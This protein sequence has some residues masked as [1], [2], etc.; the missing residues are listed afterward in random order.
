M[1]ST[2]RDTGT[3]LLYPVVVVTVNDEK[4][5]RVPVPVTEYRCRYD[6]GPSRNSYRLPGTCTRGTGVQSNCEEPETSTPGTR[7]P[8][9]RVP[10]YLYPGTRVPG[11][12]CRGVPRYMSTSW[13]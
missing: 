3:K 12:P 5:T 10:G 2:R 1:S 8:G 13:Y 7:V 6:F 11:H 4:S 9:T